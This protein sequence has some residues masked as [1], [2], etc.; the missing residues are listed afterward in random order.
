M[1][2]SKAFQLIYSFVTK[3]MFFNFGGQVKFN[4]IIT[5]RF[6]IRTKYIKT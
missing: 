5:T 3:K 6:F 1:V 4:P 2:I